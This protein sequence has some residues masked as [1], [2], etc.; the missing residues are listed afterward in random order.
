LPS[1]LDDGVRAFLP[2]AD[3]QLTLQRF[4]AE[5]IPAPRAAVN[6]ERSRLPDHKQAGDTPAVTGKS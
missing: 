2:P 1:V 6:A 4:A 5:V 3:H